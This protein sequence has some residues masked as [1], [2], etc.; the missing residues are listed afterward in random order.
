MQNRPSNKI[1]SNPTI[2]DKKQK[3][4]AELNEIPIIP[5]SPRR[6][7]NQYAGGNY[8]DTLMKIEKDPVNVKVE[9]KFAEELPIITKKKPVSKQS[10]KIESCELKKKKSIMNESQLNTAINSKKKEIMS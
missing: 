7:F 9:Q 4:Q 1:K 5:K 6:K 3:K 2:L 10:H 8:S